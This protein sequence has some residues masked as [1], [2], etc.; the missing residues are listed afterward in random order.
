MANYR[1]TRFIPAA[2]V[3]AIIV[4]AVVGLVYTARL[5]FFSGDGIIPQVD[6]S[7]TS[8]L[9]TNADRAVRLTVRG[10]I[11]ADEDFRKYQIQ[12]TP[13]ERILALYRGYQNEQF[14]NITLGNNIPAYEQFVYALDRAEM[15]D[16]LAF[17]GDADD[18]RGI[19]ATGFLY[20]YEILQDGESLKRVWT[21]SC[22]RPR[23]S[24]GATAAPINSL[25]E[26]QIPGA[27]QK[28]SSLWR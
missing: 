8:L 9:S 19:C 16:S 12:I 15:M 21:T 2:L 20:E 7:K 6:N 5:L 28:I 18:T 25:F 14:D 1:T 22:S 23:G 3:L 17:K 26:K 11:V 4:I 24:L 10:K 27:K 13:N